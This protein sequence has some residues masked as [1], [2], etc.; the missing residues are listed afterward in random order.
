M[1]LTATD[2]TWINSPT[3]TDPPM[4]DAEELRRD[5]AGLLAPGATVGAGRGGM[6]DPRALVIS[7]AGSSIVAAPGPAAV[8]SIRGSY[9]TG[10]PASG[11]VD[12]LLAADGTN[13][14]RDRVV[15]MIRDTDNPD[16][17][18]P[19]RDARVV[20]LPGTPDPNAATGGGMVPLPKLC[21]ELAWI[22]VPRSGQGAAVVTD[23]RRFSATSG[24]AVPVLSLTEARSLPKVRG[25]VRL[26][27]DLPGAPLQVCDG[28]Q[29]VHQGPW[30]VT[31][32]N[33]ATMTNTNGTASRLLADIPLTT[34]P[35]DREVR[36]WFQTSASSAAISQGVQNVYACG[37]FM[38]AN[39][40]GS[41][42]Q[43]PMAWT[44]P[45]GYLV[46]ASG[47]TGIVTVPA[48]TAPLARFWAR[49]VSGAVSTTFSSDPVITRVWVE[50]RPAPENA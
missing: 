13:P 11:T 24:G 21:E 39:V 46:S 49:V 12:T 40:L 32:L 26:R 44:N 1:P 25:L 48:N 4:Y 38:A 36:L 15:L 28:N 41:Q 33:N 5:V 6:L 14:R 9:L 35:Y 37:S 34:Q 27:L 22:D 47:S 31:T 8:E 16:T 20:Y 23:R 45:G 10:L 43:V 29:W 7:L 17:S 18:A 2:P 19:G 30:R 3:P 42:C 50:E